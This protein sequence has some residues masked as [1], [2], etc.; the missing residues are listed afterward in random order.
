MPNDR[1]TALW[2]LMAL[3]DRPTGRCCG[4]FS[5]R[6]FG[7]KRFQAI[8]R[9]SVWVTRGRVLLSGIGTKAF[10]SWDPRTRW[11]N[12]LSGLAVGRSKRP[13]GLT[14][15]IVPRGTPFHR[16]VDLELPPVMRLMPYGRYAADASSRVHLNS[17]PSTQIRCRITANRRA[18]ATIAF[19]FPRRLAICIAQA[20]SQ[21]H[22]VERTSML[23]AAS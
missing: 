6:P 1:C 21:D 17:V 15:S 3:S 2:S 9:R 5:N 4:R 19:L 23:W 7:V 12:L 13:R 11:N 16:W 22:R 8:H 18:S 14:S 20:L 10:P